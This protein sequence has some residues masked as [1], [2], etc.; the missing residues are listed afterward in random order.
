MDIL[1]TNRK[2]P[3]IN[4]ESVPRGKSKANAFCYILAL[5]FGIPRVIEA[6]KSPA[7]SGGSICIRSIHIRKYTALYTPVTIFFGTDLR[8]ILTHYSLK[9]LV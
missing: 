4:A 1:S 8:L 9:T 5:P 7:V 6:I 2:S 3:S